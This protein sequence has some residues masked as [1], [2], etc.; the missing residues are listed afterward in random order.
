MLV[1]S[2]TLEN[3]I[4]DE[5]HLQA[6]QA[7]SHG[8]NDHVGGKE[9]N[10]AWIEDYENYI[11]SQIKSLILSEAQRIGMEAINTERDLIFSDK[12]PATLE[13]FMDSVVKTREILRQEQRQ[14]LSKI[15]GVQE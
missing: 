14:Y 3:R 8:W 5:I 11:V 15:T 1:M 13:E 10:E 12:I 2:N 9:Y 7:Y 4:H 6:C